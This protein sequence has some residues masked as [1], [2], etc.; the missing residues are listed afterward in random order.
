MSLLIDG[1]NLLNV[2]GLFGHGR[3]PATLERSRYAL[4]NFL[5]GA[6]APDEL[7]STT[8]VFDAKDAPPGLPR[9]MKYQG[10]SVKFAAEYE[11]ADDL[12]EELIRADAAP[13]RLTV[14]SSD[15]RIQRA[16]RRRK[17]MAVDSEP[18]YAEL[19]RHHRAGPQSA[20]VSDV[21]P[22][23]PL[24]DEEVRWWL[25]QFGDVSLEELQPEKAFDDDAAPDPSSTDDSPPPAEKLKP[26]LKPTETGYEDIANPFPPGYGEDLLMDE[27]P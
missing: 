22:R 8:I 2:T 10:L 3:G 24:S 23:A 6:I 27:E 15:H 16:A 20:A 12:I 18:W 4:L 14:V 11:D 7:A 13:R 25:K 21:K 17:A 9:A 1:Y 19:V 5:A 26:K